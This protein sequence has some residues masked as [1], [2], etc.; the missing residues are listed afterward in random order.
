MGY[1]TGAIVCVSHVVN[2]HR[3]SWS[4]RHPPI[5]RDPLNRTA[6]LFG[7]TAPDPPTPKT[8]HPPGPQALVMA[9]FRAEE[10]AMARALL[11]A[12]GADSVKVLPATNEMLNGPV[13]AA[14]HEQEVDWGAP[15][16]ADWIRGGAWGSQR[17]ILFSGLPVAA[18]V[19][20][21]CGWDSGGQGLVG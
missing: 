4:P 7:A 6:S 1:T 2:S 13:E 9:G 16:P 8:R 10:Y 21:L 5:A 19:K 15:R 3:V 18:Q 12:V 11:D 17:V 20:G 14:I